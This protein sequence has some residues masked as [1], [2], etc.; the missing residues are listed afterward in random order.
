[1]HRRSD[2]KRAYWPQAF[3]QKLS[4]KAL[5]NQIKNKPRSY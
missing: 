1:L 3:F 2:S 4:L 5:I